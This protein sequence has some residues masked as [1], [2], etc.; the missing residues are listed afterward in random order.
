MGINHR[1]LIEVRDKLDFFI[2]NSDSYDEVSFQK[3]ISEIIRFV[4]PKY[5]YA[6]REVRFKGIDANDKQPDFVLIDYNGLI[7]F[8][9]IKKPSVKLINVTLYRDNYSPSRELSGTVQQIEKY[10]AC[11]NRLATD[12]EKEAPKKIKDSIPAGV[13]IKV[14]NPQALIIMGDARG[15]SISQKRDFELIKRQYKNVLEIITYDDLLTRLDNMI[16]ALKPYVN[17]NEE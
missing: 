13:E 16:E 14:I 9:E 3:A 12:W 1:K 10:I 17:K 6:V 11:I 7:D 4:F 2:N 5:L 8:L 15:F